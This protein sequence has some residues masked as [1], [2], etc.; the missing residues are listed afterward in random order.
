MILH[1]HSTIVQ[2]SQNGKALQ[3]LCLFPS[4]KVEEWQK[5]Y[6]KC[7]NFSSIVQLFHPW[8]SRYFP[9]LQVGPTSQQIP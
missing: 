7:P 2:P 3:C 6:Q 9:S 4:P 1:I 5:F 8:L